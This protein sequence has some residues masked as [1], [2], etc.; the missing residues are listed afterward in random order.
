[1]AESHSAYYTV[2]RKTKKLTVTIIRDNGHHNQLQSSQPCIYCQKLPKKYQFKKIIYTVDG[3]GIE[4]K[5][6]HQLESKHY[7]RAQKVTMSTVK[8]L[9]ASDIKD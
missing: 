4:V 2:R 7:S 5:R 3:G 8:E 9:N 6:H 1:M